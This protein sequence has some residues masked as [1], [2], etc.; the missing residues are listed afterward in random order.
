MRLRNPWWVVFGSLIGLIVGNG[1]VMQFTFGVFLKPISQDTGWDR[2]TISLA[3]NTGLILTG[4]ATPFMGKLMDKYGIR[5][6]AVPCVL[7]LALATAAVSFAGTSPVYFI[8]IYALMGIFAAGQTPMPY[9]KAIAS[10][11]DKKRG[12]ALGVA[13]SGVGLGTAFVPKFAGYMI[14]NYGW[15]SAYL[16]MAVLLVILAVPALLFFVRDSKFAV[17][18]GASAPKVSM[19]GLTGKE[20]LSN[21]KFWLLAATFFCVA[22]S[23]NGAIAHVVPMLTD[24][25]IS[26]HVAVSAMAVAGFALIGGR[27][28][29]GYLLDKVFAPYVAVVFFAVP[30]LG[31]GV[32]FSADT[33][34]MGAAGTIL[35]GIGLGAEV[36]LIAFLLT[37]YIGNRSFG[38][39]YGYLFAIFML[40]SGMG[41]MLMGASFDYFGEYSQGISVLMASLVIAI[42]LTLRL[43]KYVYCAG[44]D[45]A[46]KNVGDGS[47]IASNLKDGTSISPQT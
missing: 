21:G 13:I 5:I 12:L 17:G 32:L 16:G 39:V 11:F 34:A 28:L 7:L 43:G 37:R 9:S 8:F 42:L 15:R 33:V 3:L 35:I 38:E 22:L 41:P 46:N 18:K 25:G 2:G 45:S 24:R 44:E 1:P 6:I 30:L 19:A 23:A 26:P 20:A 31:L 47:D 36:D 40:G 29:S 4:I 10:W 27:L 14:A